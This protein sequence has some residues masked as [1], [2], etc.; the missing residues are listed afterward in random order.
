MS[1]LNLFFEPE[2]VAIIGATDKPGFGGNHTRA[3]LENGPSDRVYL[4]NRSKSEIF[5]RRAYKSILDAPGSVDL[6]VLLLPAPGVVAAME[7]CG[8]KGV[9]AAIIMSAGFAE[10]GEQGRKQQDKVVDIARQNNIR[11]IGPNCLGAANTANGFQTTS[12]P[13]ESMEPGHIAIIA[14][15][16]MF[17]TA[18]AD[19]GPDHNLYFS[20]VIT[21]G[22]RCDVD[23]SD[24]I[25]WLG[26]DP[27]TKVI[28]LYLESINDGKK[29][30]A[31]A[32]E[33][34][35]K[36][37]IIIL[38]SGRSKSGKD[39]TASHTGSLS[40]E[41]EIYNAAFAQ[42]GILRVRDVGE[43]INL[44]KALAAQPIPTNNRLAV[45]TV[46]GS[47]GAMTADI[48][49]DYNVPLAALSSD[50]ISFMKQ[51]APDWVSIKN[52]LDVGPSGLLG[53]GIEALAGDPEVDGILI[54]YMLPWGAVQM[55]T[56]FGMDSESILA[57][58]KSIQKWAE[59]KPI[60]PVVFGKKEF[61][62]M[63]EKALRDKTPIYSN[64]ERAVQV[65][66]QT[67]LY[68]R[69]FR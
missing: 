17:G 3:T 42:C 38:K 58:I 55:M 1:N 19:M 9:K 40:G 48:C 32:R 43:L 67:A 26:R 49:E 6:A 4:I 14:Q 54:N 36:K 20:K 34:A 37:P 52:P 25:S 22:N 68:G 64:P 65:F 31:A 28:S 46:S 24:L 33:V 51:N 23:E 35:P 30:M 69:T 44:S 59:E 21:L 18:L 66:S 2:S 56:S 5:G 16:G 41:D 57:D 8:Q 27:H 61:I 12:A 62:T 10:T 45:L 39:A 13:A 63:V 11:V 60:M 29:F 15:S 53:R 7:E 50:T 47:M